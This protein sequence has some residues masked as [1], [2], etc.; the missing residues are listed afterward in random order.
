MQLCST[1]FIR[2]NSFSRN[3]YRQGVWCHR[4]NVKKELFLLRTG[5]DAMSQP[6]HVPFAFLHTSYIS[7]GASAGGSQLRSPSEQSIR[8]QQR[9]KDATRTPAESKRIWQKLTE[10]DSEGVKGKTIKT[11]KHCKRHSSH[12][13]LLRHGKGWLGKYLRTRQIF[14]AGLEV[15]QPRSLRVS[16]V[17]Y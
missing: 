8:R 7:L 10:R 3:L 11:N 9:A 16:E 17:T 15:F 2:V 13:L 6:R 5:S 4:F 12:A 1:L 14:T